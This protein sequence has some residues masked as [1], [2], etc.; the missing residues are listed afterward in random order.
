MPIADLAAG[1]AAPLLLGPAADAE[2]RQLLCSL[3]ESL[4]DAVQCIPEMAGGGEPTAAEATLVRLSAAAAA[5]ARQCHSSRR[6][7]LS[8]KPWVE[9]AAATLVAPGTHTRLNSQAPVKG[10]ADY[11]L[12]ASVAHLVTACQLTLEAAFPHRGTLVSIFT[13]SEQY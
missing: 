7:L 12:F 8:A 4:T 5:A 6:K 13:I 10:P 3:G 2:Q 1:I 9:A 11:M